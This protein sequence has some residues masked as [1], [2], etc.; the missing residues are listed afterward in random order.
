MTAKYPKV[1]VYKVDN[2]IQ[3]KPG[4]AGQVA[5]IGAFDIT[6]TDPI[7]VSNLDE[8]YSKLGSD[9]NYDGVKCLEPLFK[10]ASSI[11]AVNITTKSGSGQ[12]ETI[13]TDITTENL[14]L[15]LSKIKNEKFNTIYIAGLLTDAFLPI[16]TAFCDQRLLNKM[17]VGFGYAINRSTLGEYTTT[18][19]LFGDYSYGGVCGQQFTIKNAR[20][21]L[22][23]IESGAYWTGLVSGLNVGNSMTKKIVDGVTAVTPELLFEVVKEGYSGLDLLQL[24]LTTF[25]CFDRENRTFVCVNS[26]QPN[27]LD[28]YINRVRDYVINEMAL[29]NYLGE[30]NRS[31]TIGQIEQE[32]DRVKDK[33]VNTLDLLSDIEYNVVKKDAGCVDVNITKLLFAGI[34][35]EIDV[36]FTIEV[37]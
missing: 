30:R 27:G 10:G 1:Q 4:M 5:L 20:E 32:L 18:A 14:A 33:C 15:A 25:E 16:I 29:H 23:L 36:Y 12:E 17:P 21:P 9:K 13:V 22:S 19:S 3:Q 24:G 2:P 35:T 6:D 28:L 8:A 11:L 26:E 37:E 31:V 7:L 34:I